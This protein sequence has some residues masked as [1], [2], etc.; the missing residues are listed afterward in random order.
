MPSYLQ[1]G[2]ISLGNFLKSLKEEKTWGGSVSLREFLQTLEQEK[3]LKPEV[4]NR[5]SEEEI[6]KASDEPSIIE[7]AYKAYQYPKTGGLV[8][9]GKTAL[10]G[11]LAG[12]ADIYSILDKAAQDISKTTGL[13]SG[14]LFKKLSENASYWSDRLDKEGLSQGFI[15]DVVAGMGGVLPDLTMMSVMGPYGL[16]AWLA[17]KGAMKEGIPGAAKG[18]V[19]GTTLHLG[20]GTTKVLPKVLQRPAGATLFGA[21]Q[22]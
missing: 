11:T 5:P 9:V 14:G 7:S 12:A 16:P 20:L 6:L 13:S 3:Q 10:S 4:T 15:H 21:L 18:A 19:E 2:L 22:P 8:Q 1:E 17:T